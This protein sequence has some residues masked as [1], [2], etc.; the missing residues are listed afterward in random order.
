[1]INTVDLMLFFFLLI[2]ERRMK[3][4][5]MGGAQ[6]LVNMLGVAK[7][8]RTR[9]EALKALVALSHSGQRFIFCTTLFF[10]VFEC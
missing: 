9:K 2:D 8:D 4:V 1:M 10:Y 6:Q 7:D 3:I 5:E